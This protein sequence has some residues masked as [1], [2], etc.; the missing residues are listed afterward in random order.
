MTS[1]NFVLQKTRLTKTPMAESTEPVDT[2]MRAKPLDD[3]SKFANVDNA[4]ACVREGM[5]TCSKLTLP[6]LNMNAEKP[7]IGRP[8]IFK[9][10]SV[11][12]TVRLSPEQARAVEKASARAGKDKSAWMREILLSAAI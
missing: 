10:A 1:L 11:I 3:L 6:Q 8:R 2:Q 9:G 12:A 5:G 7:K 4:S